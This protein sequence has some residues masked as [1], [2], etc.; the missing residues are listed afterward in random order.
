MVRKKSFIVS[1]FGCLFMLSSLNPLWAAE[2]DTSR[3][4]ELLKNKNII[5]QQE[6]EQLLQEVK[7]SAKK[8]QQEKEEMKA[9]VKGSA[10][11]AA[12]KGFKFGTTI[13]GE[14]KSVTPDSG[15]SSNNFNVN[16]AYLTITKDVNDWLAMN[17]TSDLNYNAGQGYQLRMKYAFAALKFFGTKTEIGLGHTPS[18]DYDG[19]IWPYRVQGKHLLDDLGIQASAD[20]GINNSGK[21]KYGGYMVGVFDGPGYNV[22]EANGNKIFS[23]TFYVR[24]LPDVP[25]MKGLQLAYSGSFGKSNSKYTVAAA[26]TGAD[27]NEYPDFKANIAQI[28]LQHDMFAI[29]AQYYWGDATATSAED[30]SRKAYLVE[31]FVRVP[32]AEKIRAFGRYQHYDPNTDKDDNSSKKVVAGLS[33]DMA[34]EFMPFVAYEKKTYD[35]NAAGVA[36]GTDYDQFQVGFQLKF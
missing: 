18:D 31:G 3:L 29:M 8:E 12:L 35:T 21:F 25:I 36:A 7:V 5:N 17:L 16:R 28:S 22:S 20:F 30:F 27:I 9:A 33:Y 4:I 13:Y 1:L 34:K 10:L 19:S 26:G 14:W 6:A 11:P 23:G 24:P 32:G 15:T 2:A